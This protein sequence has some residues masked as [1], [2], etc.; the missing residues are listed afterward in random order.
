MNAMIFTAVGLLV[1]A[2]CTRQTDVARHTVEEY[3]A[4]KTLRR[5]VLT[6]CA[7]DPGTFGNTPDCI[8]A[9]EAERLE[10][11]GS[12]RQSGPIGLDPPKRH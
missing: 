1:V 12:L 2:G 3:R 10:S 6:S 8:N 5:E 7:N 4:E 9:R 11:T